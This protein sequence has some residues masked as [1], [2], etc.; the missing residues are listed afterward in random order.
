[1][2]PKFKLV[3]FDLDGTLVDCESSWV[4]VHRHF[5]LDNDASLELYLR[6]EIDDEEFMRSDIALWKGRKPDITIKDVENIL[7]G[8]GIYPGARKLFSLLKG[9]GI[10]TAIVS[11]G[12]MPL[13]RRVA[14]ELEIDHVLANGLA[15]DKGG[16]L[17]GYGLLEVELNRKGL[18]MERLMKRLGIDRDKVAAVGNSSIDAPMLELAGLGIAFNPID[19]EV[20]EIADVLVEGSDLM[21][22]APYLIPETHA[23]PKGGRRRNRRGR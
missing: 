2:R 11:G 3:V 13:A 14:F 15:V 12:L 8:I 20:T 1:M 17:L 5:G 22:L 10:R 16:R 7:L 19:E 9:A 4:F 6:G 18:P 21:A 23:R